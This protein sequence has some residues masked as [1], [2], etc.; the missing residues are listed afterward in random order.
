MGVSKTDFTRGLQCNKMLWLDAHMPQ[1]KIIPPE[2]QARLDAGNEFGD[3]A[4]GI[5]GEY[6]ETT[7]LK[8][9]GRLNYAAMLEKTQ[10]WLQAGEEVVCEGAFTWYGN[11]CAV[12]IL[13]KDGDGYALYEVKN[14][15]T[16]R[17][18]F[19]TDLGFQRLIVKK[20][21]V[22]ITSSYLILP[23]DN[24]ETDEDTTGK[25]YVEYGGRKYVIIDVTSAAKAVERVA[26]RKIFAL[27]KLKKKDA[28]MPCIAVGEHCNAPYRC[29][30]FSH[31]HGEQE[32]TEKE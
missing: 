30:Y 6:K 7:T 14:S 24:A 20:S 23:C 26:D 27:G 22:F 10:A 32:K 3:I 11:Y 28:P 25:T 2:V 8:E 15:A 31:C 16:L 17:K 13:K 19:I 4:M 1:E 5:F 9:D 29:W 18:E 21:G 12:D